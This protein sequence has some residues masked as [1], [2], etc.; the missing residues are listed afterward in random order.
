MSNNYPFFHNASPN[1]FKKARMLRQPLTKAEAILW[2]VIR[3]RK[4]LGRKF[5]RQHVI[6]PFIVD[7]YCN[8]KRLAIEVDGGIHSRKDVK[9][10]DEERQK[11][12][13]MLG[14]IIL[15]FTNE[16][17]ENN[18]TFVEAEIKKYL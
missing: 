4:L 14:I 18:I 2:E 15:R 10:N 5:R 17:V 1:T 12:I 7:F 13:E 3:N 16:Q 9:A 6:G 8:E 11:A